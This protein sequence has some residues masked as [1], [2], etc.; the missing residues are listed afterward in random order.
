MRRFVVF[1][2]L[3][4]LLLMGIAAAQDGF[5]V[6]GRLGATDQES[7]EGYFAID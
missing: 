3:F 7:Q 6:R 2:A 1:V 4:G 5:S